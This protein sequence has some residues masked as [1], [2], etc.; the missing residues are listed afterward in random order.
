MRTE[1][2]NTDLESVVG[3]TV[4]ISEDYMNIGFSTLKEKYDLKN[5]T[6]RQV[7]NYVADLKDEA[8][9]KGMTNAEFDVYCR[10]KLWDNNWI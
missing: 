9:A 5:C 3:G 4:I 6:Y 1:I 7:M 8:K 10:D 2:V